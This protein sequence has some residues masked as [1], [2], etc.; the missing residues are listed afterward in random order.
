MGSSDGDTAA[1][2]RDRGRRLP[3]RP[4][5][6]DSHPNHPSGVFAGQRGTAGDSLHARRR[7]GSLRQDPLFMLGHSAG[8]VI[9]CAYAVAE[10]QRLGYRVVHGSDRNRASSCAD[11]SRPFT[12]PNFAAP[13]SMIAFDWKGTAGATAKEATRCSLRFLV[14]TGSG[15]HAPDCCNLAEAHGNR[16]HHAAARAEHHRF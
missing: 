7:L 9:A 16:T 8:G 2:R 11:A 10:D 3:C 5:R 14:A 12:M 13:T 15:V 4:H 1:E 6:T